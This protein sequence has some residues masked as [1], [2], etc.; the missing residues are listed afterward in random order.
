MT[1]NQEPVKDGATIVYEEGTSLELGCE[2]VDGVPDQ[3][4][5]FIWMIHSEPLSYTPQFV[6]YRVDST[7]MENGAEILCTEKEGTNRTMTCN[8]EPREIAKSEDKKALYK[9]TLDTKDDKKWISCIVNN[10]AFGGAFDNRS[11]IPRKVGATYKD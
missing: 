4:D 2:V 8:E 7:P 9:Y 11:L 3:V 1:V 6:D 5:G 10:Q